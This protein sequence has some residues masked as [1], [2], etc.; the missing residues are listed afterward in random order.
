[1]L[2][3]KV[4]MIGNYVGCKVSN[5]AG[6]YQVT[7]IDGWHRTLNNDKHRTFNDE[8]FIRIAGGARDNEFYRESQLKPIKITEEWLDNLGCDKERRFPWLSCLESYEMIVGKT[9]YCRAGNNKPVIIKYVHE[10][11][12][13][14][15][16]F[17]KNQLFIL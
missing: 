17:T 13:L 7:G 12:N 15:L 16:L 6:V 9:R 14:C 1:M 8:R 10:L 4:L 3:A 11:Q 5:D 2:N